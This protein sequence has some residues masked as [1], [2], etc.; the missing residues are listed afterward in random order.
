MSFVLDS[1]LGGYETTS[2][3]MALAVHFLGKSPTALEQL[4]VTFSVY[5]I[6]DQVETEFMV[7]LI[8]HFSFS[9]SWYI[10]GA[11]EDKK[12]EAERW[13]FELGWL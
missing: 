4:K 12:H 13:L 9:F 1:L 6:L 10:A 2:L 3:L 7:K 8:Y 11:S 5:H